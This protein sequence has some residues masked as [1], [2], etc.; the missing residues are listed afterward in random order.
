M[1][2]PVASLEGDA[3]ILRKPSVR[4]HLGVC[5]S[6]IYDWVGKRLL[7]PPLKL[8]P[9]ASGWSAKEIHAVIA[10]RVAGA[11]DE[12]VRALVGRLVAARATG[13][14]R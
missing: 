8:G 4:R 3:A 5:N 6:T 9:R 7:P 2:V 13:S 11:T 12:E 14:S 1:N 10:A